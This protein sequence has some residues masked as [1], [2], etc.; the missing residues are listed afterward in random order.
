[1]TTVEYHE[2]AEDELLTEIHYLEI[3]ARG[4][5]RRFFAEVQRTENLIGQ[6]PKSGAEISPGIRKVIL[7]K[8]PYS[9][10]YTIETDTLLIL[11][12]AHHSRRPAYWSD[13]VKGS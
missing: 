7:H 4:L 12:L 3:Q 8:F 11:A 5:G 1:M 10:I 2:A 13:R 9:I 6:F